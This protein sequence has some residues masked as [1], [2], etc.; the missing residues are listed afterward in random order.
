MP[1]L[2]F[3]EKLSNISFPIL[4]LL[5]SFVF[6]TRYFWPWWT[7]PREEERRRQWNEIQKAQVARDN[8]LRAIT[9]DYTEALKAYQNGFSAQSSAEHQSLNN[10]LDGARG[11]L[12]RAVAQIGNV[13]AELFQANNKRLDDW[14]RE[15][16]YLLALVREE[17]QAG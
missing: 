9:A 3:L 11:E 16:S 5:L 15:V 12:L 4:T 2:E 10:K 17:K 6:L 13:T 1:E 14:R 8:Q 7:G